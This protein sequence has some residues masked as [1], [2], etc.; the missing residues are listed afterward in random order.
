MKTIKWQIP[1]GAETLINT[2][3]IPVIFNAGS[4]GNF[5]SWCLCYFSGKVD[6]L[7][8]EEDGSSHGYDNF[9]QHGLTRIHPKST[10]DIYKD[11]VIKTR[12]D[13]IAS[14]YGS[15]ILLYTNYDLFLLNINNKFDKVFVKTHDGWLNFSESIDPDLANNLKKWQIN[16]LREM[17]PWQV[18]EFL[19]YFIWE[20]HIAESEIDDVLNYH[21]DKIVKIDVRLIIDD[22][23]CTIERLLEYCNFPKARSNF[24][25]IYQ[26]WSKL[27]KHL[28][29][30]QLVK[31]II[32]NVS[33]NTE[34]DW[35]DKNLSTVDEAIIQFKLRELHKLDLLC[36]NLNEFPSNTTDLK[37]YLKTC[38]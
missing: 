24:D 2:S 16:N 29:K 18:R 36:Y 27:Q 4:Y 23:Q 28:K 14:K 10:N 34:F 19:S 8:F 32:D 3:N 13:D 35:S 1:L 26:S 21:N 30:D 7:P 9:D 38:E 20:Q 12:L 22:F 37:K 5:L 17:Q 11:S 6:I 33:N 25:E 15:G 31:S